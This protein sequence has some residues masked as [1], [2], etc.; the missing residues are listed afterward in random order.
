MWDTKHM[1]QFLGP[2]GDMTKDQIAKKQQ[3][4]V[5]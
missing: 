3:V 5:T 4:Y 2:Q 1:E